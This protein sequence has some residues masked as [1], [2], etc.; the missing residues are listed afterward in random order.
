VF[1]EIVGV[2]HEKFERVMDRYKAQTSGGYDLKPKHLRDII[3]AEKQII[4]AEQHAIRKIS[5]N[6]ASSLPFYSWMGRRH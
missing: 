1:G 4:V 5:N 6:C 2:A 3:T